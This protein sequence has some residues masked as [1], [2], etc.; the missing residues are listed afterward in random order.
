MI[1]SFLAA[2]GMIYPWEVRLQEDELESAAMLSDDKCLKQ[3]NKSG[4]V[5]KAENLK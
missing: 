2:V 4:D 1:R 5:E 3:S